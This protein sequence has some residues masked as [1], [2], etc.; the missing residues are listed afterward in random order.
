MSFPRYPAY[1]PSGVE[2]L[3]EVPEHWVLAAP[4]RFMESCS[5]GTLIKGQCSDEPGDGLY[6]AF[7]ASGQDVWIDRPGYDTCGIVL[8]AVGARSGKTF[9]ADGRWGV[10][11]NTHCLFPRPQAD[12]DFFWYLTNRE[13]W[14]EK[15]GTA[16][17]F[18]KVKETL[19]RSWCFPPADEQATIAK[20]LDRETAKIDALIAEQQRLIELLQE[21]R[22]AVISH[23]VTKGLNPDAPMKDSGVEWLGEVPEYWEVKQVRHLLKSLTQG[24]SPNCLPEPAQGDEYGV[25]KVGCVNGIAFLPTE[26]KALPPE[27]QP[28][29][30]SLIQQG[31][32]LM[33]R[34]NTREL[35]GLAALVSEAYDRL[36]ASDL[37]FIL[38][39][40]PEIV[41]HGFLALSLRS[42]HARSQLEPKTVGTSA[43][44][45]KINQSTIKEVFLPIPPLAEQTLIL[46]NIQEEVKH[47]EESI[48]N[49]REAISLL[50]ERRSA[51]IS[52]AVTGQ[53]DVR[54]TVPEAGVA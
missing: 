11:A 2:W 5:G 43:S 14:W 39:V 31:D 8:S 54:G 26:N 51:L 53:I 27:L 18:V 25:L 1:K 33:S 28:D 46:I 22:Q 30:S 50:Q 16:Q 29:L 9:K 10:V 32:V 17:P 36:M 40:L 48:E 47:A 13:D 4:K 49:S 24:S 23:A 7:S 21:K 6:P 52:A 20:F 45:Q 42:A 44:M 35:V 34:G 19:D 3:G 12:R 38:R 15:G 41:N 37:I